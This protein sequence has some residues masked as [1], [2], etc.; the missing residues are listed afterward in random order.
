MIR[1]RLLAT[2][3]VAALSLGFVQT[4]HAA[5]FLTFSESF[6]QGMSVQADLNE[7]LSGTSLSQLNAGY[8]KPRGLDL[9][10][11]PDTTNKYFD[12][13]DMAYDVGFRGEI[14]LD[15]F[16]SP[17]TLFIGDSVTLPSFMDP[18]QFLTA[19]ISNDNQDIWGYGVWIEGDDGLHRSLPIQFSAPGFVSAT[20]D[21]SGLDVDRAGFY[22]VLDPA[23]AGIFSDVYHT[24]VNGLPGEG[25]VPTPEPTSMLVWGLGLSVFGAVGCYRRR[26][27]AAAA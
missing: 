13:N 27:K 12:G 8:P 4:G 2:L 7:N 3:A 18:Q 11:N 16:N 9:P 6:L 14:S 1:T 25:I 5:I 15:D 21:I 19:A 17:G 23:A 20:L 24:S 26:R 10:G 22:I